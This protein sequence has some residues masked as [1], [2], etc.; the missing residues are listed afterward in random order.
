M[1]KCV[2]IES[3]WVKGIHCSFKFKQSYASSDPAV[4]YTNVFEIVVSSLV[5]RPSPASRRLPSFPSL[6]QNPDPRPA[7]RRLQQQNH[8]ASDRKLGEGLGTRLT[9]KQN[10]E[11]SDCF[12]SI[13][14]FC[15]NSSTDMEWDWYVTWLY[16][17]SFECI[18]NMP[19]NQPTINKFVLNG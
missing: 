17:I 2:A 1:W 12:F 6:Q 15:I 19:T 11:K 14:V 16:P 3:E 7:S 13:E 18:Y 10:R 8:T 4:N 5:P 9:R